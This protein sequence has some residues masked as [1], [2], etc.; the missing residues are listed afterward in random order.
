MKTTKKI[1][2]ISTLLLG[3]LLSSCNENDLLSNDNNS[4]IGDISSVETPSSTVEESSIV[5]PSTSEETPSESTSAYPDDYFGTVTFE[6]IYVYGDDFDGIKIRP[7]FSK[8]EIAGNEVFSY[9]V[10]DED[11][12]YIE[13]DCVYYLEDGYTWVYYSS[14]HFAKKDKGQNQTR[15]K[16]QASARST[17]GDYIGKAKSRVNNVKS[18]MTSDDTLFLGDSFFEFWANGTN[19]TKNFNSVFGNYKTLNIG[20]SATQ[21]H[22][23][24]AIHSRIIAGTQVAPKNI[25]INIGINNVDDNGE[26]GLICAHNIQFLIED[27]LEAYPE[28]NIYYFSITRC[29]GTFAYLWDDHA[30]SNDLLKEYC[31]NTERVHYLDVMELYG[32]NYSNYEQDGLH[33]NQDGYDLFE[34]LIKENV[35]MVEKSNDTQTN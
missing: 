27:Y 33:P 34:Q 14:E 1:F 17:V 7:I 2:F 3:S 35:P 15:F 23:W 31:E 18:K 10:K 4:S 6:T 26:A 20:I 28:T 19:I 29:S 9:E 25:V 21:T 16:V 11:I 12:C 24:R 30:K 22:H 5:T 13:N 8:P 32:D